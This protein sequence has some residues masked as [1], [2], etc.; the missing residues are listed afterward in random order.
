MSNRVIYFITALIIIITIGCIIYWLR[1]NNNITSEDI[2]TVT[3]YVYIPSSKEIITKIS[4][5]I[6]SNI[7]PD[8][9]SPIIDKVIE[10]SPTYMPQKC[11]INDGNLQTQDNK[12]KMTDNNFLKN[13]NKKITGELPYDEMHMKCANKKIN[14]SAINFFYPKSFMMTPREISEF[15]TEFINEDL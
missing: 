1:S 9:L 2:K 4:D 7:S 8:V 11:K 6:V 5:S 15:E 12:I 3:K 13:N 14:E 10:K